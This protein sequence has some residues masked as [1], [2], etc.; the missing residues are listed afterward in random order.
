LKLVVIES[1]YAGDVSRNVAFCE[2][3][4][5]YACE[6][7]HAPLASHLLY[8]RFLDDDVPH[9]RAHGIEAGLAWAR[10]AEE[11]WVCLRPGE[12]PSKGVEYAVARHRKEG[13]RVLWLRFTDD[14]RHLET[15]S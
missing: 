6:Q 5:R 14:G 13:R 4:C 3:A 2:A 10:H 8:T 7:G 15:S 12:V 1:P 11:A 9:E